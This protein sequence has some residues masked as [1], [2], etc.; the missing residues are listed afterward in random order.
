MN[1]RFARSWVMTHSNMK[2]DDSEV[3]SDPH[4]IDQV[5]HE[6]LAYMH[7]F[8]KSSTV[9]T[10]LAPVLCVPLYIDG[11]DT[12]NFYIWFVLM[13][14][15]VTVRIFLVQWVDLRGDKARNFQKLNWAVGIVTLMWGLGWLMLVPDMD[16]VNYLIYQIIS[17]TVLFV[18]MVGYCVHWRT[19]FC[20][21]LPLKIPEVFFTIFFYK[22]IVWPIA[23]GSLVAFYLALKMG[24]LFSKSWEKSISLRFRNETLFN[25]LV[26]EKDASVAANVAKSD[27]IA[28]ASHD[29]RQPMQAINIFIEMID[30]THL[31]E[32]EATIF[33]KMR[34]SIGVLN[35]MFNTLLDVSKLD[36]NFDYAESVFELDALVQDVKISFI[37]LAEDKNLR[38]TFEY[39]A[40]TILGDAGLIGQIL[41]NL[42]SNSIQYTQAGQ[43]SVKFWHLNHRLAFSVEDTGCG[44]P[45]EDLPFLYKE[46]FRSEHSR[47]QYDGLGLGLTIVSRVVDR[48][49]GAI[50]VESRVN[51]GSRFTI[52]TNF[53]VTEAPSGTDARQPTVAGAVHA[54]A[55]PAPSA[56][57]ASAA[58]H[59]GIIENDRALLDAYCEYFR[60]SGY[61][62]HS[63]PYTESEFN[64]MLL[65]LP[66]LDFIL[67]DYRLGQ[68]D[69]AYF[70]KRLRE[71]FN[72]TIPACILTA[73]TS[74]HNLS[75][76]KALDIEVLY[77]PIDV[78]S[79][80]KFVAAHMG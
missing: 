26:L 15:A 11:T 2:H 45:Q 44:I 78:A 75:Q 30:L 24:Y 31:R 9:A 19:F 42:L 33:K 4:L 20:F 69:G 41:R 29:L 37:Q 50:S 53:Q 52:N 58:K 25:D 48:I 59:L 76:F 46:F 17:L 72:D 55:P 73:D 63:I 80:G 32:K 34:A 38:L 57:D 36:A 12:L 22:T 51:Q 27:F 8:A 3:M 21:V 68:K 10:I 6:K 23:L 39:P 60:S 35:H 16:P 40:C 64:Q 66:K 79:I 5:A 56:L 67:S 18:G 54:D 28:T 61:V 7:Q 74:P 62:V 77:K 1:G 49:G 13:A 70:I 65:E 14:L 47:A 43:V 71:E